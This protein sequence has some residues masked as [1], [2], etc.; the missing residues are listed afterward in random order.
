MVSHKRTGSAVFITLSLLFS[1]ACVSP[2]VDDDTVPDFST[3]TVM[4]VIQ[5]AGTLVVGID[6][7]LGP[8]WASHECFGTDKRKADRY[9]LCLAREPEGFLIDFAREVAASLGVEAE[10]HSIPAEEL[11]A[12]MEPEVSEYDLAFPA[13]PV[14][15]SLVREHTFA[16]P[17]YVAHQRLLVPTEWGINDETDLPPPHL[18]DRGPI[19]VCQP[20]VR[21]VGVDIATLPGVERVNTSFVLLGQE[22]LYPREEA[23]RPRSPIDFCWRSFRNSRDT[24][25]SAADVFLLDYMARA[26]R[27]SLERAVPL[28]IVGHQLTTEGF[29]PMVEEAATGM[30]DWVS[31]VLGEAKSEGR[32]MQW[33]ERWIAPYLEDPIGEP[34]TMTIEEAAALFPTD[35]G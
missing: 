12:S 11:V 14:T 19:S 1:G 2:E 32:Y 21:G 9:V 34:P 13:L 7:D 26:E 10:F 24:L 8:P 4:G 17:Y 22:I 25:I 35:P 27:R 30:G 20:L 29:A 6:P 18:V 3:D 23:T 33:Y 28:E 15:E 16:N 5:E 31:A